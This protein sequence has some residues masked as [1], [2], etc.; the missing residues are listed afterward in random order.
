MKTTA[1]PLRNSLKRFALRRIFF[2]IPLLVLCL[3]VSPRSQAVSPPPDGGY[4]GANTAE[5]TDALFSIT[6]GAWNTALGYQALYHNGVVGSNT[7]IG[8]QALFGNAFGNGNTAAGVQS[9]YRNNGSFNT[10]TGYRALYSNDFG[11]HNTATGAYALNRNAEGA[12]NTATG[13]S[14]LFHNDLGNGNTATGVQA[15]FKNTTGHENTAIGDQALF[16]NTTGSSTAIGAFA[17]S[18]NTTGDG[19][20]A[21][22]YSSLEN[23]TT[24][25]ANIAL[26]SSAGGNLTTGNFNIDIG[27]LGIAGESGTI[28]IGSQGSQTATYIVGISGASVPSGVTVIVDSDGH[29]GTVV[30]SARFK[31]EVKPM[32]RQSE[33]LLALLPV[34]FRYKRQLDPKGIPQFGLLAEDVEKINPDLVARDAQGKPYSVRYEAVNAMLLNEFLK[35]HRKVEQLEA[36]AAQ[37]AKEINTL[38][39]TL[40]EQAAQ[41]QKVSAQLEMSRLAPHMVINK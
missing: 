41:I 35:E 16:N 40:K 28:R 25:A 15:L 14:A 17:L 37:Q 5:G 2:V 3:A 36:T 10:A 31:D 7:G 24:G 39:S 19:N 30:S 6:S 22:G 1:V 26:G 18:S 8:F 13:Y 9:L 32:D 38:R 12:G 21:I 4:P 11:P 34:T 27:N 29:L 33:S 23:N 20:T